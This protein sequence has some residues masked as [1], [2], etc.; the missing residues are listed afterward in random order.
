MF[1]H[2]ANYDYINSEWM[3]SL[4]MYFQEQRLKWGPPEIRWGPPDPPV[5]SRASARRL[6]QKSRQQQVD[7]N[8][9]P[10]RLVLNGVA[11]E[12]AIRLTWDCR[13]SAVAS[14]RRLHDAVSICISESKIWIRATGFRFLCSWRHLTFQLAGR[15][16]SVTGSF[17]FWP[18]IRFF[19]TT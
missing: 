5:E 11:A 10:L 13:S 8:S 1:A 14:N 7:R 2:D 18:K 15:F 9:D 4:Q 3:S 19:E 17:S 12:A 6:R 16:N